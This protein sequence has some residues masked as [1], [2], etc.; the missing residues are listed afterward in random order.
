[1]QHLHSKKTC[2]EYCDFRRLWGVILLISAKTFGQKSLKTLS[3]R[4]KLTE[5]NHWQLLHH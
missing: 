5:V 4:R 2:V 3:S 1:M